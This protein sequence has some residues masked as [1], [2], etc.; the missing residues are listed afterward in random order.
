MAGCDPQSGMEPSSCADMLETLSS[1][2]RSTPGP[3]LHHLP[4]GRGPTGQC[5]AVLYTQSLVG[6]LETERGV[7]YEPVGS[8]SFRLFWT[9]ARQ[10][11]QPRV[12]P[13]HASSASQP[14][15]SAPATARFQQ[16]EVLFD[17]A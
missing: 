3:L 14:C 13:P 12:A 7:S 1:I 16:Q 5:E 10:P 11:A 4:P 15:N 6:L 2:V 8:D 9:R 17:A